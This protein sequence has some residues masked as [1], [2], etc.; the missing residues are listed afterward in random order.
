MTTDFTDDALGSVLDHQ[1]L[2]TIS[3]LPSVRNIS[4]G[5]HANENE[6][7]VASKRFTPDARETVQ[8]L[9]INLRGSVNVSEVYAVLEGHDAQK[10]QVPFFM[11][12]TVHFGDAKGEA[13]AP[14]GGDTPE[15]DESAEYAYFPQQLA[16]IK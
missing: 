5:N 3:L 7:V 13:E 9:F 16:R 6:D 8:Q 15:T 14:K 1:N 11:Y 10:G 2:R 12:D 4:G